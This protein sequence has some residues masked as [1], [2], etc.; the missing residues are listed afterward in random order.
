MVCCRSAEDLLKNLNK[1]FVEPRKKTEELKN[2]IKEK[3]ADYHDKI[4]DA[5]NLLREAT[6][7][8]R[9]ADRLS[10]INQ[11]NLTAVEVGAWS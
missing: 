9:E 5:L 2:E 1:L 3:L 8:I 11:R 6:N 10:A 7:K 4:D